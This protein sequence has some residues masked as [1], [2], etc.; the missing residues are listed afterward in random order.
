MEIRR[1]KIVDFFGDEILLDNNGE[2]D[3]ARFRKLCY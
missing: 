1:E 3:G 2:I